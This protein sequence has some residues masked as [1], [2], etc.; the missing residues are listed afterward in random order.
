MNWFPRALGLVLLAVA[1]VSY[2]LDQV[3]GLVLLA[4]S[5]GILLIAPAKKSWES[6]RDFLQV[7]KQRRSF[8]L[9]FVLDVLFWTIVFGAVLGLG[10]VLNSFADSASART[11]LGGPALES[12]A[13]V[14]GNTA[15]LQEFFAFSALVILLFVL[16][17]FAAHSCSRFM[18][19]SMIVRDRPFWRFVLLDLLWWLA[20]LPVVVFMVAGARPE[21]VPFITLFVMFVYLYVTMFVYG[22]YFFGAR[23]G[24][25]IGQGIVRAFSNA[26]QFILPIVYLFVF[27]VVLFQLAQLVPVRGYARH[28]VTIVGIALFFSWARLYF[29]QVMR[30]GKVFKAR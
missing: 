28:A 6:L 8:V 18:I 5:G 29:V 9:I 2:S 19:W 24:E 20:W 7:W 21:W 22:A 12:I 11:D 17:W 25:S 1:Y 26:G 27:F 10:A 4:I 13:K 30:S 23:V 15:A 3:A 16:V 14:Q